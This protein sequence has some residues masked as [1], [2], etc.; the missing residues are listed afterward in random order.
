MNVYTRSYI[1]E[2]RA[3]WRG[4]LEILYTTAFGRRRRRRSERRGV[5][6]HRR[7]DAPQSIGTYRATFPY[8]AERV[9]R[10]NIIAAS[11]RRDRKVIMLEK[12]E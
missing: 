7:R 6:P 5:E 1:S 8:L 12:S 9:S 3:S 11:P 2:P 10:Q 4:G